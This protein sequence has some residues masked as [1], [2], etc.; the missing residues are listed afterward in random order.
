ME[1]FLMPV[2]NI[3]IDKT[4]TEPGFIVNLQF[5]KKLVQEQNVQENRLRRHCFK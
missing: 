1:I 3:H 2:T 5:T 4:N